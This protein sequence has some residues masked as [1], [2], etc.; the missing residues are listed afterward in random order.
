MLLICGD[1]SR[2]AWTYFMTQN[3]ETVTLFE[4]VLV[5]E[6]LAGT[7]SAQAVVRSDEG[8]PLSIWNSLPLIVQ[9]LTW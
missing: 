8:S 1:M 7:P 9:T 5:D 4:Q 6:R 3:S 2:F